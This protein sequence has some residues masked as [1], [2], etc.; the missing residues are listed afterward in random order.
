MSWEISVI[1]NAGSEMFTE[2]IS[3]HSLQLT[4]AKGGSGLSTRDEMKMATGVKGEKQTLSLL[5]VEDFQT[6]NGSGKILGVQIT[7][8]GVIEKYFLHQ[9][10]IEGKLEEGASTAVVILQDDHGVE[11]PT[12]AENPSFI[13]ELRTV[14]TISNDA[15]ISLETPSAAAATVKEMNDKFKAHDSD[16]TAHSNLPI[17]AKPETTKAIVIPADGWEAAEDLEAEGMS[18]YPFYVDVD[19]EEAEAGYFPIVS[20]HKDAQDAA[21]SAGICSTAQAMQGKIRFWAKKIPTSEMSATLHLSAG[22]KD[23]LPDGNGIVNTGGS[24][25]ENEPGGVVTLDESGKI[26][27]GLLPGMGFIEMIGQ[28]IQPEDRLENTIYAKRVWDVSVPENVNG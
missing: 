7:N 16:P 17:P 21:S 9:I 24:V 20:L 5:D 15:Q 18:V 19:V 14:L 1:T 6:E 13:Y 26:P 28:D 22:K 8:K 12:E 3:G 11:I 4:A 10:A 2:S 25:K 23:D 27:A